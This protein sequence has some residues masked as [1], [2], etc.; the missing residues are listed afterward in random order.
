M[1]LLVVCGVMGGDGGGHV[2]T[3]TVLVKTVVVKWQYCCEAW[4][5]T[6]TF[7]M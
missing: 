7:Y 4:I 2:V 3:V 1:I 5:F 6:L